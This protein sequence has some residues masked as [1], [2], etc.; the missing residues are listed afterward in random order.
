[1]EE[2]RNTAAQILRGAEVTTERYRLRP[3]YMPA[4]Q[5]RATSTGDSAAHFSS[6]K[7]HTGPRRA[8]RKA[9]RSH[10][11]D[12]D[13]APAF[14]SKRR[15]M[16]PLTEEQQEMLD[17]VR[18]PDLMGSPE[19]VREF[20]TVQDVDAWISVPIDDMMHCL[21]TL[22]VN[23]LEDSGFAVLD[24]LIPGSSTK[25]GESLRDCVDDVL[26]HFVNCFSEENDD[27]CCK[28]SAE[29][30]AA[31]ARITNYSERDDYD[32]EQGHKSE[33]SSHYQT[34]RP[35]ILQHLKIKHTPVL[36]RK[37][38]VYMCIATLVERLSIPAKSRLYSLPRT[39]S[40][41]L[42]SAPGCRVQC[43]HTD[44]SDRSDRK[45]GVPVVTRHTLS[46]RLDERAPRLKWCPAVTNWLPD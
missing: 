42:L 35:A 41:L 17:T 36:A 5:P 21:R 32:S 8:T 30:E 12:D 1:M 3:R 33:R 22:V 15:V 7:S 19:L 9:V 11:F 39:G 16:R 44:F 28:D 23:S 34:P 13:T 2:R 27:M 46:S 31:W 38:L 4:V 18:V 24:G 20:F 43:S 10:Q 25:G 26:D 14:G 37:L 40:H 29:A 45:S 6:E